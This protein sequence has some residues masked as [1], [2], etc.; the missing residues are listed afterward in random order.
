MITTESSLSCDNVA[1]EENR[2]PCT[3]E[4]APTITMPLLLG[5]D[6]ATSTAEPASAVHMHR[7]E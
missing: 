4:D 5:V 7:R 6:A 2:E 3:V 1:A